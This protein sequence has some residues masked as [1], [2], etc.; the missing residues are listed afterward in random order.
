MTKRI[1]MAL[2]WLLCC[3][4]AAAQNVLSIEDF[5]A[6]AGKNTSVPIYL[7][8]ADSIV[9]MQFDIEIPYAKTKDATATLIAGR[10]DG[11]SIALRKLSERKYTV[12]VM[13]LQN[14]TIKGNSGLLMRFPMLVDEGAQA[15]DTFPVKL[16]NIVL[17]NKKGANVA[18]STEHEAVFTVLR[19]PTPDLVISSLR[20]VNAENS[21]EPGGKLQLGYTISNQGTGES[22][23]GWRENIYLEDM[24]GTR[25]FV[26]Y[27]L[28]ENK[29]T[30][31]TSIQRIA[32]IS[33]PQVVGLDGTMSAFVEIVNLDKTG[34]LIADQGNNSATSENAISL[35]RRVFFSKSRAELE[36]GIDKNSSKAKTAEY[37]T[38]TRSGDWS[39]DE[40]FTLTEYNESG[41]IMLTIPQTVTIKAGNSAARF[42]IRAIDNNEVNAIYRTFLKANNS[43]YE[44]IVMTVDVEDDDNSKLTLT[45]DKAEYTEGE[46]ITLTATTAFAVKNDL[47]VEIANTAAGRFYPYIRSITIPAGQTTASATTT[48]TDNNLPQTDANVTFKTTATGYDNS[49]AVIRLKDNDRP[50]ISM[51]LS[52]SIISESDGYQAL[53]ATITREGSTEDG[54][55]VYVTSD[56][57]GELY[58]DSNKNIIPNGSS[59]VTI[60]VSVKDNSMQDGPRAW[61]IT[62]ALYLTDTKTRVA[63][64]SPSYCQA[65]ITVTDNDTDNILKLSASAGRLPEGGKAT[66]TVERNTTKGSQTI[67]ISVDD[68]MVEAPESVTIPDGSKSASFTITTGKNTI[69]GDEHLCNI[70]V[71]AEGYQPAAFTIMVGDESKPQISLA[72]PIVASTVY[73]GQTAR[74]EIDVINKGTG[75]MPKGKKLEFA[76]ST[77]KHIVLPSLYQKGS[78]MYF[79]PE[80]KTTADVPAGDTVRMAY[81]IKIPETDFIGQYYLFAWLNKN[82]EER[83]LGMPMSKTSPMAIKQAFTTTTISTDKQSY[84][85]DET[86]AIEGL[87]SNSESGLDMAG[88]SIEVYLVSESGTRYSAATTLDA[89]GKFECDYQLTGAFGGKYKVGACCI[90]AEQREEQ[91]TISVH[92]IKLGSEGRDLQLTE[93]VEYEGRVTLT[94]LSEVAIGNIDLYF[95]GMPEDWI[96]EF[97]AP[98]SIKAGATASISYKITA[99]SPTLFTTKYIDAK[100]V[101]TAKTNEGT[102][103]KTEKKARYFCFAQTCKLTSDYGEEGIKTTLMRGTTRNIDVKITNSG[104][105]ESGK[106]G[107]ECPT[108]TPW[109]TAISTLTNMASKESATLTLRL[110]W[111]EN[112]ITDGKYK[113]FVRLTSENGKAEVIPVEITV[114]G[115][116]L[117]TLTVDVVDAYTLGAEDGNGPHVGNATVKVTNAITR[118]VALTGTTGEDGKWTTSLLK[119][120]TYYV[121][122]T[123]PNHYYTEKTVV[124]GPGE[125]KEMQIFLA[126]KAV[127]V[128][129]YVEETEVEDEYETTVEITI[130]PDIPQAIVV[131]KLPETF[132]CGKNA[133]LV[134]LENKG[135]LTA[136]NPYMELPTVEGYTFKVVSDYPDVIYP[137]EKY[138][139]TLEY[140]GK[141]SG[142]RSI[143]GI[144]M[145]YSYKLGGEMYSS[146]ESYAV[147]VGCSNEPVIIVGGGFGGQDTGNG[148][149]GGSGDL[150]L[151]LDN[152]EEGSFDFP[153]VKYRD[154]SQGDDN[155]VTFEFKQRFFLAR[156][157]FAG[158]LTVEN[159]QMSGIKDIT[160]N[161]TVQTVDGKDATDLFAISY[162]GTIEKWKTSLS[163]PENVNGN[164]QLESSETG[165]ADVLYVPAKEAA[166]TEA[167]DYLFGGTLTYRDI[168]TG[169]MVEVKLMQTRLT[170]DPSPDVHL[171]YF[172]QRDFI[173]D[174]PL[175]EK[176][177]PWKPAQFALLVQ[178][179]GAG[180]VRNLRVE[181]TEP[182]II[183]NK[184]NLDVSLK[185]LY[186]TID[187]KEGTEKFHDVNFGRIEPGQN[188][189]A[190]WWFYCNVSAY[191]A[192]Y[193]VRMSKCSNYGEE[194][195]LITL[196][197]AK[198]LTHT[199]NGSLT[200]NG[201][202][203]AKR[204]SAMQDVNA[205]SSILL[206]NEIKDEENLP[207]YV[208]DTEG[209]GTDDIEIVSAS[210][211]WI[212]TSDNSY[213]LTVN[214]SRDGWVYGRIQDPANNTMQLAKVIRDSDGADMTSNFWQTDRTMQDDRSIVYENLLHLADN[215][216]TT[217]TYSITYEPK[218][219]EAPFVKSITTKGNTIA[220]PANAIQSAVVVFEEDIDE[221]SF[222]PEDVTLNIGS[223][224]TEVKVS[225][226]DDVQRGYIVSWN[227]DDIVDGN[228]TLTVFT[229]GIKN[230]EGRSGET[231]KSISWTQKLLD[232]NTYMK[233][234]AN[235]DGKVDGT[236]VALIRNYATGDKSAYIIFDNA[237]TNL[238]GK[239]DGTDVTEIISISI[240]GVGA[241]S[242]INNSKT[243]KTVIYE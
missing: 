80:L 55:T 172:I 183:D 182:R 106:I 119:E 17:S 224:V 88:R 48:I 222:G 237:D 236:D 213:K 64:D 160:I 97:S 19:T 212:K 99:T 36:E 109:L 121:H 77:D 60:P 175:T 241:T 18:T 110:T 92:N 217:E 233:G 93:M 152:D 155:S 13:S 137:G 16:S 26:G 206:L 78:P 151:N 223:K 104:L 21:I 49:Q 85:A 116:D 149:A 101:A 61:N 28:Y 5:T 205:N 215:V 123:A 150:N 127:N 53:T 9:A 68:Q 180:A 56:S 50:K 243:I 194:F 240:T 29:L 200:R 136:Y 115:T 214:A 171:T 227:T 242:V 31:N 190:R 41:I 216:M 82:L 100:L 147:M 112:M 191:V 207:D 54:I 133:F 120:G 118:E 65:P 239:I 141:E 187:G 91:T 179:K 96:A 170:V 75:M 10:S 95:D 39:T 3:F 1:S 174:N 20:I 201:S 220:M 86:V 103:V 161:A 198:E 138:D 46:Q 15:D 163:K 162:A 8:N 145:N 45:T 111:Q 59:S 210:T 105:K 89:Q 158:H 24:S 142:D 2:A 153:D 129:Y 238:D 131:P 124:I 58:F 57:G 146:S 188:I 70:S 164:W 32:E 90:G 22:G 83:E 30:E 79:L 134:T 196:D 84:G 208:I 81:D 33:L 102:D 126:Y 87:M 128:T 157:A 177:E 173:S 209:N 44:E 66:L 176:V 35:T 135:R 114:V 40:E 12:V 62:C 148:D 6:A 139:V 67:S 74:V 51:T 47:K 140:E 189:M 229:T 221:N 231:S 107:I 167:T 113:S 166:L 143:G 185:T 181:T 178:N 211:T 34:E 76:I 94:N 203:N 230:L 186:A 219:A 199:V 218:P 184:N 52:K 108:E 125:S 197:G 192:D 144:K 165:T 23:D 98:N 226:S 37:I 72:N 235:G 11:H 156:Q 14:K 42:R 232:A 43:N 168:E 169:K 154:Y 117:A 69:E 234:D 7:S 38:L 130:V 159:A 63:E 25:K 202:S 122:V 193:N 195:N 132:G 27:K 71:T 204:R 73:C 228:Y 225:K 4:I